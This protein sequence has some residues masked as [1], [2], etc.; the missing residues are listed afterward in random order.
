[1][2][3]V[4]IELKSE[5]E[6][7]DFELF[8]LNNIYGN[9]QEVRDDLD[10]LIDA[11][12][13][14]EQDIYSDF[15]AVIINLAAAFELIVKFRL[16]NEHWSFIFS[17][18]NKAKKIKLVNG[19]FISVDIESGVLRLKNICDLNY[20]FKNLRKICNFRNCLIHFTLR[21]TNIIEVINTISKA[22]IELKQFF[23]NEI[24]EYLPGEAKKDFKDIFE[25][26]KKY[27]EE[28]NVLSMK[29]IEEGS[30]KNVC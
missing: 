23:D 19:D 21:R 3:N 12:N 16:E 24:Y 26:L 13:E 29:I 27:C 11:Y 30:D 8:F 17:D 14:F 18:I 5:D 1:M 2:T 20:D 10:C 6:I 28:I 7:Y 15:R 22:I 25:S 9:L 4:E